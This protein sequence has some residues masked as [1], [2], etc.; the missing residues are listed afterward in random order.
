VENVEES[1]K[2][3]PN[4]MKRMISEGRSNITNMIIA[5]S[6]QIEANMDLTQSS[7]SK[8]ID[9][10]IIEDLKRRRAEQRVKGEQLEMKREEIIA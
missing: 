10:S 2:V 8:K 7:L 5:K 3:S 4:R 1:F 9:L 6:Y